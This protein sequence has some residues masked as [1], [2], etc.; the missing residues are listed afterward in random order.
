MSSVNFYSARRFVDGSQLRAYLA[1]KK[2]AAQYDTRQHVT[3]DEV[4]FLQARL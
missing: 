4:K 2:P 3:L 1:L